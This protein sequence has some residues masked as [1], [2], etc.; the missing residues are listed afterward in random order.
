[1]NE[2]AGYRIVEEVFVS[3]ETLVFRG[4]SIDSETVIIKTITEKF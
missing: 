4:Q 3:P 2:I 1:M